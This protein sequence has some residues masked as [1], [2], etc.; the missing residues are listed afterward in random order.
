MG[1]KNHGVVMPNANKELALNN[2]VGAG[3]GASG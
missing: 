1:A 2:L 3:F